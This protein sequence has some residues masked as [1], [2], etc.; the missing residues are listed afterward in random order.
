MTSFTFSKLARLIFFKISPLIQINVTSPAQSS[1]FPE[2]AFARRSSE[3]AA[4]ECQSAIISERHS[5]SAATKPKQ[6]PTLRYVCAERRPQTRAR[7]HDTHFISVSQRR[8]GERNNNKTC[9]CVCSN[10]AAFLASDAPHPDTFKQVWLTWGGA[11]ATNASRGP[12]VVF[13]IVRHAAVFNRLDVAL[14]RQQ[15]QRYFFFCFFLL[16]DCAE[17][18][19]RVERAPVHAEGRTWCAMSE[20]VEAHSTRTL[21]LPLRAFAREFAFLGSTTSK[22]NS[23][24]FFFQKKKSWNFFVFFYFSSFSLSSHFDQHQTNSW[25]HGKQTFLNLRLLFELVVQVD[26][27]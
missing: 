9:A 3:L 2:L 12:A 21:S 25:S 10:A 18:V 14:P 1:V 17:L 4:F 5:V 26:W 7:G 16:I 6:Q 19:G 11:A 8:N 27:L 20:R 24:F 15:Q 23:R 22:K 13:A